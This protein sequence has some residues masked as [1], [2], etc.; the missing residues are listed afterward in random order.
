MPD[1][2]PASEIEDVAINW[3]MRTQ[4]ELTMDERSELEGW[5][6]QDSR[7]LGAFVRAQ[8]AW[9]YAERASALGKI[10]DHR[11]LEVEAKIQ[12]NVGLA[13]IEEPRRRLLSRRILIG[14]GGAL[15]AS[16]TAAYVL[17]FER[18]RSLESGVG[19]IRHLA[20]RDGTT[21]TLDTNTR[22]DIALS[23][24]DRRFELVRGKLFLDV[25]GTAGGL[26]IVKVGDLLVETIQGAFGLETFPDASM[27]A[28]VT[29]GRLV[30]SQEQGYFTGRTERT[31]GPDQQL[32]LPGNGKLARGQ[33]SSFDVAERERR[34]AWRSGMLSFGGEALADAVRA[35]ARYNTTRIIVTDAHLARQRVTGL[36][37]ATDPRGFAEAVA[38]SFGAV[39]SRQGE[40]I[41]I[42]A[43]KVSA[44]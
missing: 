23:S 40:V 41:R 34:L 9:I 22:V 42:A 10:P 15:A 26:L 28:L 1:R 5:L 14:G 31:L 25:A 38:A 2:K 24:Q 17:G 27:T 4:R 33:V 3:A 16:V 6:E 19:E 37:K 36:F 35:F 30:V 39:V 18:F 32:T 8:A 43:E 12:A 44:Q 29:Q 11:E 21:L 7:H 20:L 13:A